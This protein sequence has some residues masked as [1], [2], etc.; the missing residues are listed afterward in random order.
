MGSEMCIRD[1]SVVESVVE[2]VVVSVVGG[3][4]VVVVVSEHDNNSGCFILPEMT[5]TCPQA[6][7][8]LGLSIKKLIFVSLSQ[9]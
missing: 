9:N 3:G 7:N 8:I 5:L 1:R 6:L 4:V 2:S